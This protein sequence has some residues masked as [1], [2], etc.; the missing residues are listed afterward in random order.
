MNRNELDSSAPSAQN[1]LHVRVV[2]VETRPLGMI[3]RIIAGLIGVIALMGAF[4][5]SLLVFAAVIVIAAFAVIYM[6]WRSRNY[7]AHRARTA[8]GERIIDGEVLDRDT[9]DSSRL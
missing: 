3:G 7:D 8:S 4:F 1:P 6:L 2:R 5:L 9:R